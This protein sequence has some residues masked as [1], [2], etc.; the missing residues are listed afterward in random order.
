MSHLKEKACLS[1]SHLPLC[2]GYLAY[3]LNVLGFWWWIFI[4]GSWLRIL[5]TF[6]N[7]LFGWYQ[8]YIKWNYSINFSSQSICLLT[9]IP[10]TIYILTLNL[11]TSGT[12]RILMKLTQPATWILSD[13][14]YLTSDYKFVSQSAFLPTGLPSLNHFPLNF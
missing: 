7:R 2:C 1:V 14:Y 3:N 5:N 13:L 6:P 12:W 8:I 9:D 10:I 4:S 11:N